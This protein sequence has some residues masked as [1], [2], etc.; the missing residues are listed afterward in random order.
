MKP[1]QSYSRHGLNALK[2]RV[3]VQG[4][5]AIDRRTVAGQALLAWRNELLADL[6]GEDAVSAQELA[7][8]DL[9]TRT[10]LY[11]DS[12]DAWLMAQPSLVNHR[13]KA[14]LPV[15][16]ERLALQDSL[17]RI[18]GQLGLKRR[19]KPVP[20]LTEYIETKYQ[21]TDAT[22]DASSSPPGTREKPSGTRRSGPAQSGQKGGF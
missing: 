4:W 9:A 21:R 6:G 16:R 5:H 17:S 19:T 7:L 10:R 15:L 12:L 13:K 8:V 18:L 2:V 20:T 14:V 3:K 1:R 22:P 11:V